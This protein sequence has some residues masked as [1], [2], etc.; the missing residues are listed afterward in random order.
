MGTTVVCLPYSRQAI[1]SFWTSIENDTEVCIFYQTPLCEFQNDDEIQ[2][3]IL[4]KLRHV[5]SNQE[6]NL[7]WIGLQKTTNALHDWSGSIFARH[8]IFFPLWWKQ[9]RGGKTHQYKNGSSTEVL[10][11]LCSHC[12]TLDSCDALKQM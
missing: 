8:G 5:N 3:Y 6:F 9:K 10:T 4:Y 11:E 2:S 1:Q 12:L 7:V